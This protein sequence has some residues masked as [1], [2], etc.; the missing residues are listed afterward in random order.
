MFASL[1]IESRTTPWSIFA[2]I[3][4]DDVNS[5]QDNAAIKTHFAPEGLLLATCIGRAPQRVSAETHW[6]LTQ[7]NR[8]SFWTL[9]RKLAN[10]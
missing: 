8:P 5:K 1:Q 10:V 9:D 3:F 6:T 4:A 2:A 7:W